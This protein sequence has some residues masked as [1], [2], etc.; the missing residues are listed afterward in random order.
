M[1]NR[2]LK[3]YVYYVLVFIK[4]GFEAWLRNILQKSKV[5]SSLKTWQAEI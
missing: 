2:I 3:G 4:M 1:S 5:R